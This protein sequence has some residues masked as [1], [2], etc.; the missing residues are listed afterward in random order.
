MDEM[1]FFTN[2]R[3]SVAVSCDD[4]ET[5]FAPSGRRLPLTPAWVPV[6]DDDDDLRALQKQLTPL[7]R[8]GI[9]QFLLISGKIEEVETESKTFWNGLLIGLGATEAPESDLGLDDFF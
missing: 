9:G 5:V 1:L 2:Y 6:E 3:G 7:Q 4:G 8:Q